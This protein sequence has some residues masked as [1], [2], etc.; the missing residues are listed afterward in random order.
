[1]N[2][3]SAIIVIWFIAFMHP[4]VFPYIVYMIRN[5][6]KQLDIRRMQWHIKQIEKI[7]EKYKK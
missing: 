4:L 7:E 3:K 6:E 5:L 1:M 2:V